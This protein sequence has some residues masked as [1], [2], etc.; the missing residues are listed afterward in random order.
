MWILILWVFCETRLNENI[1]QLFH[2]SNY[3]AYFKNKTTQGGGVAIYLQ[4]K[5][6]AVMHSDTCL[7][8]SHIETVLI[9][10]TQPNHF[11]IGIGLQTTQC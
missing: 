3:T 2:M 11:I 9:E 6:Q 10:V 7:Q 1:C 8:L 4:K 5:F